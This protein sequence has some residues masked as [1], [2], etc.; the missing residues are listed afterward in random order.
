MPV[1]TV[2]DI[3]LNYYDNKP[4][5]GGPSAPTVLL[6]MGSGGSGRAWHLH[7]VPALVAAGFR[8]ISFDNRGI[9]PSD[10]CPA[11]FGIDDLVADTAALIEELRLGPCL[12]AGISMGAHIAQELALA[13]PELVGRMVLMATRARPDV[14]REALSRAEIE[15]YDRGVELPDAYAAVVQAMQNLSPRTLDD[16]QQ[17]RDWLDMLELTRVSGPGYRAQLGVGRM[18]DRREAYRGI[19]AATRVIA[20]QD[21]LIAPPGLGREVAEAIPGAEFEV[22][23]DCGHYGYLECPDAVN[24]SLVE[25]LRE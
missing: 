5:G 17:A 15:L 9:A 19:R 22:V 10:E 23:P 6:V 13:R 2:N 16:G 25:F 11:G 8:V 14:L 7:Q 12:L 21:D 1:I 20:F 24:K 18:P 3:R 4:P